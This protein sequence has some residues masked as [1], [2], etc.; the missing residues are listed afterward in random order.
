MLQTT[1]SGIPCQ[2]GIDHYFIQEPDYTNDCSDV[3]YY[4]YEELDFTVYDSKG[5]KAPWLEKKMSDKD[6][7]KIKAEIVCY[8]YDRSKE[9]NGD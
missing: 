9:Y 5:Y 7:E 6:L 8:I 3:D 2:V 4:G 1:I